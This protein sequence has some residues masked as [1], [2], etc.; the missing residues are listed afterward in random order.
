ML[1]VFIIFILLVVFVVLGLIALKDDGYDY[2]GII[3]I[4]SGVA[5]LFVFVCFAKC[6][7]GTEQYSGYIYSTEQ[8]FGRVIAH[9]RFS[10]SAG[11]DT[12]P[13]VC[14][15]GDEADKAISLAGTGQKVKII[16]ESKGFY[17]A[18]NP[19]ECAGKAK[20]EVLEDE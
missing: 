2:L 18:N 11:E 6:K 17:F 13:A 5:A 1:A 12:Q 8:K 10:E 9:V 19:F 3:A 20:I 7:I 14:F 16:V 4:I 15:D